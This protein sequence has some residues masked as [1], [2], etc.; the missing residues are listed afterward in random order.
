[1]KKLLCLLL[2]VS[3]CAALFT[4]CGKFDV[5]NADI[6]DY[7]TLCDISEIPYE[8]LK[9]AYEDYR[10]YLSEDLTS[11]AL[12]TGYTIDFFVKAE[13][14]DAEGKV[15]ETVEKWTHNTETD[16]VKGYDVCKNPTLFDEALMYLAT[17]AGMQTTTGRTVEVG[18][19]FSFTMK[20][21]EDYEDSALAGKNIKFTVNVKKVLPAVYPDSKIA[22]RLNDFF[23]VA[24]TTKETVEKGD[25]ITID[26]E[27]TIDGKSFDGGTGSNYAFV[28]GQSKLIRLFSLAEE[29]ETLL[30]GHSLNEKFDIT[31]KYPEDCGVEILAGKE[32]VYSIKIKDLYNDTEII[33]NTTDYENMWELKYALRVESYIFYALTNYIEN[34]SELIAYPEKLLKRFEKI[35]KNYVKRDVAERVLE[36]AESGYS[37]TKKEMK[38]ILY[39]D[40]ADLTYIKE[41]S[42]AA[43][44]SY[45]IAVAIQRELGLS[46]TE[47]DYK[48]DIQLIAEEYTNYYGET[49]TAKDIES[50][51]GKE[52]LYT[53]FLVAFI[54]EPLIENITGMPEIPG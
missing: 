11:C 16:M 37:Y 17:E 3:M 36:Y 32:V 7:V 31:V 12:S 52:V 19:D 42:E 9:K 8:N 49:Y 21:K 29:F 23:K 26:Y 30:I 27:G 18:K 28:I 50:L 46:Y 34:Q 2:A 48:K 35:F 14:L 40:G 53:S 13:L 51:Y 15:T 22:E 47:E 6:S 54:T 5:E 44:Y 1:M 4:G 25:T 24:K 38:E 10:E 45:L 43:A 41:G 20:L 39:P 33:Q